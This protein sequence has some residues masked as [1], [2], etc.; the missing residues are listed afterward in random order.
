VTIENTDTTTP[1]VGTARQP[2]CPN[3]G[4]SEPSRKTFFRKRPVCSHAELEQDA[5][6]DLPVE[7]TCANDWHRPAE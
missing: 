3:C 4:H 6:S 2:A 5:L 7:C 1:F